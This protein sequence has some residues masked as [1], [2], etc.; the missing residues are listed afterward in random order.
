[1]KKSEFAFQVF[2]FYRNYLEQLIGEEKI[3][4]LLKTYCE[5]VENSEI[6][7]DFAKSLPDYEK[8]LI[9]LTENVVGQDF[10]VEATQEGLKG[11][12]PGERNEIY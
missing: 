5:N 4:S 2:E 3:Q 6:D 10:E 12:I 8:V 9:C 11:I 1:M 7:D